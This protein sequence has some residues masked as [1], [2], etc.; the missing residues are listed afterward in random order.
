[1]KKITPATLS[2]ILLFSLV[3]LPLIVLENFKWPYWKT[4]P[5]QT[6]SQALYRMKKERL[7][8]IGEEKGKTVVKITENGKKRILKYKL[9]ELRIE[10]PIKW[11]K[12]WRVVIFDIPNK[13]KLARDTLREKLKELGFYKLQESVFVYPYECKDEIDFVKEIYEISPFVR[14][15]VVESIDN[16]ENILKYFNLL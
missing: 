7:A 10:K 8:E 9:E 13:K 2:K 5:K 4:P 6:I 1:M 12:K 3:D 15:L 11:D 16:S 14:Y